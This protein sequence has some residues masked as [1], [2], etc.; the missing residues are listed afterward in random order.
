MLAQIKRILKWLSPGMRI[1]RWILMT[2]LGLFFVGYG[3][4][5]L[6]RDELFFLQVADFIIVIGG[7]GLVVAGIKKMMKSFITILLPAGDKELVDIIY[8]KRQ[9]EKGPSIVVIGGGTGLSVLL[10][11]LKSFTSKITAIVTVADDGG[12]SGRLR[13]QFDV[14]PPG[15]IRNC[16]VALADAEPLMQNLFQFRFNDES[17]FKGH[18]FGNIFITAMTKLTDG[19]FE[20]AIEESSKVLAIRGRVVPATL[21]KVA[22]EA[23]F[24]DGSKTVGEA[25]IPQKGGRI[26]TVSLRPAQARAANTALEAIAQAELIILGPGSLYTSVIPN[27][28]I[29]EISESIVNSKAFKIYICN[30]MTQHGETDGYSAFDHLQALIKHTDKRIVDCCLVNNAKIPQEFLE[31][32]RQEQSFPVESDSQRIRDA[33]FIVLES[34]FVNFTNFVRHDSKKLAK[35]IINIIANY[36]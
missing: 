9:L 7:I 8:R 25:N 12:S 19:D 4:A 23:N 18:N 34:D 33:G 2:G 11:G 27:L 26:K 5:R 28:L 21:D 35:A 22:L 24:A 16:L 17:E 29:K 1:K 6:I 31:K 3:S 32:Y 14:L 30:V 13:E 15:D 20:K 36:V 10:H